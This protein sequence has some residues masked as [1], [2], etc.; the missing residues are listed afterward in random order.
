LRKKKIVAGE[1]LNEPVLLRIAKCDPII[2]SI[3][4]NK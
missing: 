4:L 3:L 2:N 1:W